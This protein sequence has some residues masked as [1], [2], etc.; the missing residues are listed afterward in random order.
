LLHGLFTTKKPMN[1]PMSVLK[2]GLL[3]MAQVPDEQPMK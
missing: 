1:P 2:Y 3:V